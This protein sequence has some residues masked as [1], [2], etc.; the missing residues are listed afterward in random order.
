MSLLRF[1]IEQ[2]VNEPGICGLLY[3]LLHPTIAHSYPIVKFLGQHGFNDL[4]DTLEYRANVIV[5]ET[6]HSAWHGVLKQIGF[7]DSVLNLHNV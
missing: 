6:F 2:L 7:C 1:I 4:H 3:L 5:V